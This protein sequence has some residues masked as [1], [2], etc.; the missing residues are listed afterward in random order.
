MWRIT[1]SSLILLCLTGCQ[2]ADMTK[3]IAYTKSDNAPG[4]KSELAKGFDPGIL[5]SKDGAE[6]IT[7]VHIAAEHGNVEILK[8]FLDSG[9]NVNLR[10]PDGSTALLL[11][12]LKGKTPAAELLLE[13]RADPNL[14][15]NSGY[16][17]LV[18]AVAQ[19][20]RTLVRDLVGHGANVNT[21]SGP[22]TPLS[23]AASNGD[24]DTTLFLLSH[25]ADINQSPKDGMTCRRSCGE[26]RH[27]NVA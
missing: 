26:R 15:T 3:V 21:A 27:E 13:R 6:A 11:A 2:R 20:N 8:L 7:P 5:N 4:V 19:Q 23:A 16:P 14:A 24:L 12:T 10:E 22:L 1:V 18:A 25:G 9:V 17:P